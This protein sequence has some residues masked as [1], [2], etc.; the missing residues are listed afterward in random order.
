MPPY[1]M[2]NVGWCL[3]SL[4]QYGTYIITVYGSAKQPRQVLI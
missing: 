2:S 3:P 4:A 1:P